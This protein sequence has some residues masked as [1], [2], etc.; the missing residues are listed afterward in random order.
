MENLNIIDIS[1][2]EVVED[3]SDV[4]LVIASAGSGKTFTLIEKIKYLI[5]YKNIHKEEILCISFTN[6]S[7]NNI[8]NKL[9][10]IFN[11][12]FNCY[13]FHKLG[14]EIIKK[15]NK[16]NIFVADEN[17]LKFIIDDFF[18][19]DILNNN[20]MIEK[21]FYIF[22]IQYVKDIKK[23]YLYLIN[24]LKFNKF[25]NVIHTF[26]SLF[27]C[28]DYKLENYID[29]L[30]EIKFTLNYNKYLKE[31]YTL[32]LCMN[33]YIKYQKYLNE[34]NEVDFDDIII[35]ASK[36]IK[37]K[38]VNLKIKYIIIDEYQDTSFI[39]FN[40]IKEII[41]LTNSKLLVVGDDYQSIFSFT[42]CDTSL[43]T[44]FKTYFP[45]AKIKYLKYTYRNCTELLN[46]SNKFIMKN[47]KQIKKD[48]ISNK[49][50]KKPIVLVF[51]KD[52]K[53]AIN[54]I[55]NH[56]SH[57]NSEIL[58]LG[59]NNND[60]NLILNDK[61]INENNNL[62][63]KNNENIKIRYLTIHKSKGL[64]SENV[65]VIN[66][67]NDYIGF[68][69]KIKEDKILRLVSINYDK[70]PYAEERRLFYVAITR[71]KNKVFLLTPRHNYSCFINEI[72]NKKEVLKVYIN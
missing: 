28:N 24:T 69:N 19:I 46:F 51:Y 52:I 41:N 68:P 33:I 72:K 67:I 32:I 18:R 25:K 9:F 59:R 12:K 35:T 38:K 47:K 50:I 26:I 43:F 55:L 8:E 40:L 37:G 45:N 71:T 62:K 20:N 1:Q 34:N 5:N 31:K 49:S 44:N 56:L 22:D 21:I 11:Y 10:K 66:L 48:I 63:F 23:K 2:K 27:K 60:I 39:R 17:L 6:E 64:E 29:F 53:K 16:E 54:A 61:L 14:L 58:I 15:Y 70:F 3:E 30:K 65:I 7:V 36:L 57:I 4:L 13:T 42:G